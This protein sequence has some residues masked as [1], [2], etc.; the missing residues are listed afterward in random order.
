MPEFASATSPSSSEGLKAAIYQNI[1]RQIR[2]GNCVLFLGPGAVSVKQPN[3]NY[4][5]LIELCAT[6]LA[7]GLGLPEDEEES[8]AHVVSSLRLRG[9]LSDTLIIAAVQDFYQRAEKSEINPVLEE[10]ANLPFRLI[11]NTTPDDYFTKYYAQSLREFKFDFYNFRKPAKD[12]IYQFG[13]D[14]PPLIYNL[15]GSYKKPES[16]VLTYSDQLNYI[17]KIIGVQQLPDSLLAA[18]NVPRFYLFLGF[19]FEDWTLRITFD[20]LFRNARNHI[21]PFAYPLKGEPEAGSKSKVFFQSEFKMEFPQVDLEQFV[22]N[23]LKYYNAVDEDNPDAGD[24]KGETRANVLILH[25]EKA[26]DE[27]CKTFINY[28]KPLRLKVTTLRDATGE[29]DVSAWIKKQIDAS[30]IVVPLISADFF[31]DSNPALA[32]L[33]DLAQRNNPRG[34]FLV[35]PVILKTFSLDGTPL[36]PLKTL[37]PAKKENNYVAVYGSGEENKH[38]TDIASTLNIYLNSIDRKSVV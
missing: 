24:D 35:M 3:G 10:L 29:G 23:L 18:F 4:R 14:Q 31:D 20:A 21:T 13:D 33:E 22:Q 11:I 8:L 28:L 26:D 27:G 5:P 19:D 12:P 25:N 9:A 16:L 17:N 15:F 6:D 2:D 36:A 1:A 32:F 30:Q 38:F 37:R 7:K 34:K